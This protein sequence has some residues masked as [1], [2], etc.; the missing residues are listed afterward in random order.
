MFTRIIIPESIYNA[1]M[2][3]IVYPVVLIVYRKLD[4]FDHVHT[5]L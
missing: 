5:R 2:T 3:L 1:T 4:K